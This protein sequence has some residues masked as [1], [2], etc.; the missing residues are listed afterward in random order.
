MSISELIKRI[1][2]IIKFTT[3]MS[4]ESVP[5]STQKIFVQIYASKLNFHLNDRM[6]ENILHTVR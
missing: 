4:T 1:N 2:L 6:I 3:K 5:Y